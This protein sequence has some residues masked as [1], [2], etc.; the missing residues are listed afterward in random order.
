MS[1]SSG[2]SLG[3]LAAGQLLK[4]TPLDIPQ[5]FQVQVAT[6]VGFGTIFFIVYWTLGRTWEAT[7]LEKIERKNQIVEKDI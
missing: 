6:T 5:V 2:K 3:A 7:E 1:F 4:Q